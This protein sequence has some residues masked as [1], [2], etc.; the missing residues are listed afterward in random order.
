MRSVAFLV[1]LGLSS[2]LASP[3]KFLPT[4]TGGAS[5]ELFWYQNDNGKVVPAFLHGKP[6]N[7]VSKG[8]SD[9]VHFYLYNSK[10]PETYMEIFPGCWACLNNFIKGEKTIFLAHGF[11]SDAFGGFGS[12]L[13]NSMI[14]II[15]FI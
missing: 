12:G 15:V 5:R 2:V 11:S 4:I 14:S 9:D 8:I 1:A 7:P 10:H 13:R 6:E 3:V